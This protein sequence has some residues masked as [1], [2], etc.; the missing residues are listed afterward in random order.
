MT[1]LMQASKQW[2]VRPAD[3][4]FWNLSELHEACATMRREARTATV[5]V[6]ALRVEAVDGD[7][8]LEGRTGAQARLTN[9]S[10]SQLARYASAPPSYLE[11]LPATLAAQNLNYGLKARASQN[12]NKLNLLFR[13]QAAEANTLPALTLR[14]CVTEV[15]ERIWNSELTARLLELEPRGWRP[16]PA[17]KAPVDAVQVRK[18]TEADCGSWTLVQPGMD[19]SP[20]GLYASDRDMFVFLIHPDKVIKAGGGR[21][22]FRGFFLENS[23][24]GNGRSWR[25]STFLFDYVCYNSIVWGAE[26]IADVKVKHIGSAG[27]RAAQLFNVN[28]VKYAESSALETEQRIERA[29]QYQIAATREEVIESLFSMR[30]LGIG[31]KVLESAYERAEAQPAYGSPRSAWGMSQG[32]TEVSQSI[33]YANEKT[34]VD[35]AAGKIVELAF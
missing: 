11:T 12:D 22:M 2:A 3:E 23:E 31:R 24:V 16:P 27:E 32:L 19:I 8:R 1:T 13:T 26:R 30:Q 33:P 4:R 15:Y 7:V 35:T 6:D 9:F 18:A 21:E 28:V 25:I 29:R 10:F 34:R 20:N 5:A 14:A 17:M